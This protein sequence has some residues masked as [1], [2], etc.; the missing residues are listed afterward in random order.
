VDHPSPD[1]YQPRLRWYSEAGRLALAALIS[2]AAWSTVVEGQ[3][4]RVPW[5]FWVDIVIGL[6]AFVLVLWRRK[7]PLGVAVVTTLAGVVSSWSVGPG[8]LAGVSLATRRRW[9]ELLT[10][11]AIGLAV[12][13]LF[14]IVQPVAERQVWW[15]TA[16]NNLGF[17]LAM[18]AVGAYVGSR[19]ELIWTLRER[20]RQ[21]ETEQEARVARA[22]TMERTRIAREMHDVLAHRIS[23]VSMHAGALSYRT[24]LGAE[25]VSRSAAVIHEN[26]HQAL[27]DLR[28]VLGVLREDGGTT[29]VHTPQ[30][31]FEDVHELVH[32]AVRAGMNVD[33]HVGVA[34]DRRMP[35][36][37]GRTVYRIV[38]EA[39]TNAR[40]HA[41][42]TKVTV[43]VTGDVE[44]GVTVEVVNPMPVRRMAP[45]APGAGLGL[46]GLAERAEL[47][48]GRLHHLREGRNFMLAGWLPWP[49]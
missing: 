25:E 4:E 47:A 36:Q 14:E 17:T 45:A 24:D 23:L 16:S 26:A 32:E 44:D 33:L 11:G 8:V 31:S 49:P 43:T 28:Q 42:G 39:L 27:T 35:E 40:K 13:F 34:E 12:G 3:R 5:L 30:P 19:R 7:A 22:R 48:G 21:A 18:L 2:L 37:V 6:L 9:P 29:S 41:P 15:V 10:I 20:A 38:Q 46:V 1:D